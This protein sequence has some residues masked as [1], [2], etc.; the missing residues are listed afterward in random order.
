MPPTS[1]VIGKSAADLRLR[2]ERGISLSSDNVFGDNTAAQIA[3]QTPTLTGS[4]TA[5]YT[6]SAII[7]IAR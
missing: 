3:Q 4:P 1:N 2:K 5:G 7:G 6:G